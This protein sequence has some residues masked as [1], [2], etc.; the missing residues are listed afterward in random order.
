[1]LITSFYRFNIAYLGIVKRI[2][3][4]SYPR[5][6]PTNT[7]HMYAPSILQYHDTIR[8]FERHLVVKET[9]VAML[10]PNHAM[11][12]LYE[13]AGTAIDKAEATL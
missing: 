9:K 10:L 12:A 8:A 1:M 3:Y 7:L 11:R 13:H 2:S 4:S 6:Q 5:P